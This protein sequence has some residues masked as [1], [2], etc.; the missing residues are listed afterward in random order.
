AVTYLQAHRQPTQDWEV[1]V[2]GPFR[3]WDR[4]NNRWLLMPGDVVRVTARGV[5]EDVDGKRVVVDLDEDAYVRSIE[6]TFEGEQ[7]TIKLVLTDTDKLVSDEDILA[8]VVDRLWA[9]AVAQKTVPVREI[10]GPIRQSVQGNLPF[11]FI[12][13]WDANVRFLHKAVLIV[14]CRPM[15]GNLAIV[16]ASPETIVTSMSQTQTVST[17][18]T[19]GSGTITVTESASAHMHDLASTA[20]FMAWSDPSHR[21]LLKFP[22]ASDGQEYGVW[23]GRIPGEQVRTGLTVR[24][25]AGGQH[26]HDVSGVVREHSHSVTIPEHKHNVTIP[27]HS[28]S[29]S[30][31]VSE[32]PYPSSLTVQIRIN[33]A[34][35]VT[36]QNPQRD[37]PYEF[38]VTARLQQQIQGFFTGVPL[39]QR[40]TIEVVSDRP[41]D[42]EVTLKSIVA[43]ATVVPV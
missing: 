13:D 42:V 19:G 23:V 6:R 18:T 5:V 11:R 43:I 36:L 17:T 7:E 30:F 9:L 38:D 40:N 12:V 28:H 2:A 22:N 35:A 32:Q 14:T 16:E 41:I 25:L 29:T 31:S 37:T 10:H 4:L 27:A 21:E 34:L 1:E 24:T 8:E 39:Q 26:S 3:Q 15:R 20:Q 33:G